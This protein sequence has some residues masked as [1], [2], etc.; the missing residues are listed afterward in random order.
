MF[1]VKGKRRYGG[2]KRKRYRGGFSS[3]ASTVARKRVR[4]VKRAPS[5]GMQYLW[6]FIEEGIDKSTHLL[7]DKLGVP[8]LLHLPVKAMIDAS[9]EKPLMDLKQ[10]VLGPET[11]PVEDHI[12]NAMVL[13]PVKPSKKPSHSQS[14]SKS[15]SSSSS[16]Q[17]SSKLI[18]LKNPKK[19]SERQH[20]KNKNKNKPKTKT[21]KKQEYQRQYDQY[22]GYSE[23]GVFHY[24]K[25]DPH[26]KNQ[27][28]Y[29]KNEPAYLGV[30]YGSGHITNEKEDD[31]EGEHELYAEYSSVYDYY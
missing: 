25:D 1:K 18:P 31:P 6:R 7:I 27:P 30:E 17:S 5:T 2:Y 4:Y 11:T 28:K 9:L 19:V 26:Y 16:S 14:S 20:G 15:S 24:G 10:Y 12:E 21:E 8:K 29:A 23:D 22:G 3:K 13:T